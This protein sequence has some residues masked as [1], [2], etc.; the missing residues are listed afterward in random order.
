MLQVG[1][2]LRQKRGFCFDPEGYVPALTVNA[3]EVLD[4][5]A[6][7]APLDSDVVLKV[8]IRYN[9]VC[10]FGARV[11]KQSPCWAR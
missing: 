8:H 10:A 6:S 2:A 5:F 1:I 3:D 7:A 4:P 9:Y 11:G